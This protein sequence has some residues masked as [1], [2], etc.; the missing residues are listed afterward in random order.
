MPLLTDRIDLLLDEDNELVI[1]R[2]LQFSSGVDGIAQS[3][4]LNLQAF[5]GEWFLDLEDGV[6]YYQS[7]LGKRYEAAKVVQ[8][9]RDPILATGGVQRLIAIGSSW[10]GATRTLTVSWEVETV[11][12]DTISDTLPIAA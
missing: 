4:R 5:M 3:I 8:A 12:G 1:D 2:D 11:F 9:F 7:I 10:D 6:P